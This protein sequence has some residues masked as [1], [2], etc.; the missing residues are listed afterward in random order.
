MKLGGGGT[1]GVRHEWGKWG[2]GNMRGKS[3]RQVGARPGKRKY[4]LME[5]WGH[6]NNN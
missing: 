2:E 6:Q 1:K 3:A 5:V 4:N